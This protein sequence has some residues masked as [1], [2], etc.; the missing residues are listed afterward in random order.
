VARRVFFSF[1]YEDV[2]T[3]RANVV[4]KHDV[5]KEVG[6]AGFFDASLWEATKLSGKP[7]LKRLINSGLEQTSVTCVLIGTETWKRPWVRY[8]VLKSY[9][10]GNALLGIHINAI[11]DKNNQTF[12]PGRNPF[13]YL[14]FYIDEFGKMTAYQES[15]DGNNWSLYEEIIP[16]SKTFDRRYW[17]KGYRLSGWVKCYDWITNDGYN[18][19]ADW[20]ERAAQQAGR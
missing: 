1:H 18:N 6:E 7:A 12:P 4:R 15:F 14:G 8:E 17:S 2:K 3:F 20:I 9:E 16:E 19:F 5:T 10:R 11:E 13:D